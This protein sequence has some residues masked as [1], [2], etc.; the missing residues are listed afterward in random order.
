MGHPMPIREL[1]NKTGTLSVSGLFSFDVFFDLLDL[2][3]P[4]DGVAG[5][6]YTYGRLRFR[7]Q[8]EPSLTRMVLSSGRLTLDGG[9][10]KVSIFLH[11][12]NSF[13]IVGPITDVAEV[14]RP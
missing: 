6:R 12:R 5:K 14:L 3:D 13:G 8:L 2:P 10:I 7:E 11:S 9:G 1:V 4:S